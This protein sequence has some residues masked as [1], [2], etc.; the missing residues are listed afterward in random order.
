MNLTPIVLSVPL[1]VLYLR[2]PNAV[3]DTSFA[4]MSAV[5]SLCLWARALDLLS[6]WQEGGYFR[7]MF[8]FIAVSILPFMVL[9][10]ILIAAFADAFYTIS[11][12]L[13][14]DTRLA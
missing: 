11:N 2:D 5:S 3:N 13:V 10:L 7:S 8:G 9:F 14:E 1:G 12:S 6:F 4:T